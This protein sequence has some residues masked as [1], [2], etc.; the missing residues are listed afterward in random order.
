MEKDTCGIIMPI[1]SIDGCGEAHW[2]DVLDILKEAISDA[3]YKPNLV[4]KSDDSGVI[5]Q[6]IIQ[7]LYENP[8][9][10][11]DVSGKNPNVMFELGMRLAFDK[12]TIIIKDDDTAYSFD[13]AQ[14]EHIPYPR[15]LRFTEIVKFKKKLTE[16]IQSTVEKSLNDPQYTTFLKHFGEFKVA[17]IETKEVPGIEILMDEIRDL[18]Y[19][20]SNL[21][22]RRNSGIK[23]RTIADISVCARD[24]SYEQVALVE[25]LLTFNSQVKSCRVREIRK[26]HFHLEIE[27][28]DGE[29]SKEIEGIILDHI[30]T[31]KMHIR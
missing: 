10:V 3:G 18:K 27:L 17:K 12:P 21:E 25:S 15:D 9:V 13:T 23:N 4:S 29:I 22:V 1:S 28:M 8:I 16:K 6:R 30:P 19:S 7:N 26:D 5:Q 2:K 14:I 11:C 31:A 24:S 20:V